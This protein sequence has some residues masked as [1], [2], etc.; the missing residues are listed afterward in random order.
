MS[1]TFTM[2]TMIRLLRIANIAML[3]LY[4]L[5][6]IIRVSSEISRLSKGGFAPLTAFLIV[7]LLVFALHVLSLSYA[8]RGLGSTATLRVVQTAWR[9]NIILILFSLYQIVTSLLDKTEDVLSNPPFTILVILNVVA[10]AKR[11]SMLKATPAAP[12]GGISS[13]E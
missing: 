13:A 9:L 1:V 2:D 7:A 11:K 6:T 3:L 12:G 8:W 5:G 10:L 4:V